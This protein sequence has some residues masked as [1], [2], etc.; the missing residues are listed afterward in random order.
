MG[1]DRPTDGRTDQP[2]KRGVELRSM[3]LKISSIASRF[4]VG[5][6]MVDTKL[7][8]KSGPFNLN[9]SQNMNFGKF[10]HFLQNNRKEKKKLK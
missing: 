9:C 6:S 10:T 7:P 8:V 3:R 2:T 5:I 1:T 4:N